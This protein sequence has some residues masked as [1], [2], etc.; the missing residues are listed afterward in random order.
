[1]QGSVAMPVQGIAEQDRV[2]VHLKA[3]STQ[4]AGSLT[5]QLGQRSTGQISVIVMVQRPG[6]GS[7]KMLGIP[8]QWIVS[9]SAYFR[10]SLD[11]EFCI[12]SMA[13]VRAPGV[14][15][16]LKFITPTRAVGIGDVAGVCG[17]LKAW[18]VKVHMIQWLDDG[19]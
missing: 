1:M 9:S 11:Q 6:C 17:T 2:A 8:K 18:N 16:A 13:R 7:W 4:R 12:D 3:V 19:E 14:M 15:A 10:K 5:F